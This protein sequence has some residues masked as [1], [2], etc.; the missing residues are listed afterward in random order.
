MTA[1]GRDVDL[2]DLGLD[3]GRAPAAAAGAGPPAARRPAARSAAATRRCGCTCAPGAAAR[4]TASSGRIGG[5][6]RDAVRDRARR[7]RRTPR[8]LGADR[9]GDPAP[10]VA[11]ARRPAGAWRPAARWS[12]PAAPSRTST[13]TTATWCGPTSRPGCTRTRP[14]AQWDPATAV[15]VGRTPFALPDEVE[16]AVVQVMTYLVENEQ[17]ALVGAG[18]VPRAASIR[19]SARSCSCSRCRWPTRPATWRCS[20]R[21]ALLPAAPTRAPRRPAAGRRCSRCVDEPDFSL[22]SFLLS[23]L[24]EGS[25]VDLLAFLDEHAPDPVTRRVAWLA[26]H[27]RCFVCFSLFAWR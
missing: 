5:A 4:A 14:R 12:R 19:T 7:P 21:R 16:A 10:A 15:D 18:A 17:A 24:G 22:A 26:Q 11:A 20:R 8:W 9:A 2:G 27:V 25:F 23:V 3:R 13:W 1:T 6:G